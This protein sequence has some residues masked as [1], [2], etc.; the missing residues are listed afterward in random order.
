M[1]HKHP[2]TNDSPALLREQT[3]RIAHL[4]RLEL[5]DE[6]AAIYATQLSRVLAYVEQLRALD[7]EGVKP[8]LHPHDRFG[9]AVADDPREGLELGVVRRLAPESEGAFI[10]VPKV[11]GGTEGGGA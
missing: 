10:R 3:H 9:E 11:L 1:G 5:T 8:M 7:L 4:A 2:P 6:Q